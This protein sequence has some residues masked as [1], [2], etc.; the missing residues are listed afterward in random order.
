MN[1][2]TA[3]FKFAATAEEFVAY[4]ELMLHLIAFIEFV[5]LLQTNT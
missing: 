2:D 5:A 4:D 3:I 1:L